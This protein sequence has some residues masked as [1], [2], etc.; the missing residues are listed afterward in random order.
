ML[1]AI[2]GLGACGNQ[3]KKPG[4]TLARVNGEEITILQIND[5][6][7]HAN[8]RTDDQE[9]ATKQLLESLIDRQLAVEEATRNKIHRTPEVIQAIERAKA[10]IIEQAY[11]KSVTTKIADPSMAEISDYFHMHPEY[12]T[13]RKQFDMQQLV[14][15][16][17]DIS[18]ELKVI[19]DSAKSLDTVASWL[20]NRNIRYAR[21]QFSR[22]TTDLPEPMV[23]KF[24]NMQKGHLFIVKEG[25]NILLNYIF[26]IKRSPVTLENASQQI[27]QYL[28]NKKSRQAVDD[29]IARLRSLAKIEYS[30][31]NEA[32]P[33]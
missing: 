33:R 10:Q 24:K 4:Q 16:T 28:I 11:L 31:S 6:L 7:S 26:D 23:A 30:N 5:E 17:K 25:K 2:A 12:F 21:N 1:V 27:E 14:F 18:D 3:E 22:N 9:A 13:E 15:A 19:M 8:I 20:N 29:E 32:V